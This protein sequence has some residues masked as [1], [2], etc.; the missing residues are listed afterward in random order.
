MVFQGRSIQASVE[1]D[2]KP[3]E[4]SITKAN[5]MLGKLGGA[6]EF[7]RLGKYLNLSFI[8]KSFIYRL[9]LCGYVGS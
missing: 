5:E 7:K 2:L 6:F 3:L 8:V 4:L 9:D 1:L